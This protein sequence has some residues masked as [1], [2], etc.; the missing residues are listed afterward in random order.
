MSETEHV[1][2]ASFDGTT[3]VT[4][5]EIVCPPGHTEIP[6]RYA[7]EKAFRSDKDGSIAYYGSPED[8]GTL[9]VGMKRPTLRRRFIN[10]LGRLLRA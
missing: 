7:H 10:F 6:G 1:R 5:E 9:P 3:E 4:D 2:P 8:R